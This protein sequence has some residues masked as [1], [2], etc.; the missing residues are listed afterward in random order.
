MTPVIATAPLEHVSMDYARLRAEGLALL[1]RLA[2]SQWTD[3]N[4]HDPGIT[5]LEQLCY[6]ITDLGYRTAFPIAELVA[7]GDLGLPPAE[8]ILT[9]DPV[10]LDD[11]RRLALDVDGIRNAWV[12]V[13]DEPEL[14][15][16]HHAE[17]REL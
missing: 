11:V 14:P 16:Y 2:T 7:G 6:A 9:T 17:A 8:T 1:E 15:V 12:D 3:F 4:S 10:T 13:L 5:I